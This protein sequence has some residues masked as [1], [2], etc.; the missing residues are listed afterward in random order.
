MDFSVEPDVFARFPG[1]RL[2]VVV[3]RDVDNLGDQP[4]ITGGWA[5]A[6]DGAG[7]RP[8]LRGVGAVLRRRR[9][10]ATCQL[11]IGE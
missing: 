5:E 10:H 6:W 4:S 3:A 11:V 1:M 7:T 9:C 2:A 8:A